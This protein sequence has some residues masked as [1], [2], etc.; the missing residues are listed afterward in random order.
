MQFR[1]GNTS[2][3][4]EHPLE[5][6]DDDGNAMV[7]L[8]LLMHF[9][10]TAIAKTEGDWLQ[11]FAIVCDK[12]RCAENFAEFFTRELEQGV[13]NAFYRL[14]VHGTTGAEEEFNIYSQN[15]VKRD[16]STIPDFVHKDLL[17]TLPDDTI[18]KYT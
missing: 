13:F 11:K 12:Y 17:F 16:G 6:C 3:D 2:Y 8:F 4:R 5:L 15:F 18:G 7:D 14:N 9:K 1:E 10:K